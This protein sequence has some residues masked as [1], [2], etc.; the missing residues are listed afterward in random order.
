MSRNSNSEGTLNA[1]TIQPDEIQEG[2]RFGY[3][4]VA[5]IWEGWNGW[6]AFRGP[7]AW[8]DQQVLDEGD[9]ISFVAAKLLFPTLANLGRVY[10]NC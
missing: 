1:Y 4:I 10:S 6:C 5:G 8:T 3:K 7:T 2:D 9:E